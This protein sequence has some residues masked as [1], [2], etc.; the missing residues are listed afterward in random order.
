MTTLSVARNVRAS[1][2]LPPA[3][4]PAAFGRELTAGGLHDKP[5]SR[6]HNTILN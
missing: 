5:S 1:G 2:A 4:R 6:R 3:G